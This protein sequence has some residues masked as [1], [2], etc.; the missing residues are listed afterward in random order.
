MLSLDN[1]TRLTF[2]AL[3]ALPLTLLVLA[4]ASPAPKSPARE[5][6]LR[7]ERGE[8]LVRLGGC[9]ECHTPKRMTA[10][11][12]IPD[13]TRFLAGHPAEARLSPAPAPSPESGS[14]TTTTTDQTAWSGPWG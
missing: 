7:L 1:R 5:N 6:R 3:A 9:A 13:L 12:P 2:F 4:G 11:G 10:Q 8:H 14:W